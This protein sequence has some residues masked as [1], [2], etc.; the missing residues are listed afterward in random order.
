V[1]LQHPAQLVASQTHAPL[2]QRCP[3]AHV[4]VPHMHTPAEHVSVVI[5]AQLAH[6]APD[7]PHW[8]FVAGVTQLP[9]GLVQQPPEQLVSSQTHVPL[10]HRWPF[11]H[12]A[13]VPHMHVP[14]AQ[15]SASVVEH[16]EHVPPEAPHCEAVVGLTHV[17]PLQHPVPQV[18]GPQPWHACPMHMKP[19]PQLEQ[20]APLLPHAVSLV[21][22]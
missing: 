1:P 2:M 9:V 19:E 13:L 3:A 6:T 15:L 18:L 20:T 14:L 16:A 21:P 5:V 12:C 10:E 22:A 7:V 11:A 8:A 17:L 4:D